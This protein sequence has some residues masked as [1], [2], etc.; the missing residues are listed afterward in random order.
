[1]FFIIREPAQVLRNFFS[2]AFEFFLSKIENN[3]WFI[4]HFTEFNFLK[5]NYS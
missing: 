1:M 2:V 3:S 5:D 4:K